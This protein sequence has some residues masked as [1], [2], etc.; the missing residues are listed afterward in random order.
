MIR[1]LVIALLAVALS[2][3]TETHASPTYPQAIAAQ[4]G[5][6]C[7][8]IC[9]VCH[10][11]VAGGATTANK[12]FGIRVR[13]RPYGLRSGD[14]QQLSEVLTA[15]EANASDVDQDGVTDIAE[16]SAGTDPNVAGNAPLECYTP[17]PPEEDGG[18]AI[19]SAVPA[20]TAGILTLLLAFGCLLVRRRRQPAA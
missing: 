9:T 5:S 12:P 19:S 1:T 15:L 6:P 10:D 14:T 2:Y 3:A 16:L 20:N 13:T 4:L 8:P 7:P 11:T 18:C 17:P